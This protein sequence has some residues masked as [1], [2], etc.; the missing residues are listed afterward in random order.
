MVK[1][2]TL[3]SA[4]IS[5]LSPFVKTLFNIISERSD[6]VDDRCSNQLQN[7]AIVP[8]CPRDN[9]FSCFIFSWVGQNL[10]IS[11]HLNS[12]HSLIGC[13]VFTYCIHVKT[14]LSMQMA[15]IGTLS[16]SLIWCTLK[17]C[18][19]LN[20]Y[21]LGSSPWNHNNSTLFT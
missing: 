17:Y 8:N 20:N 6:N 12:I 16:S 4:W 11:S 9:N 10:A 13:H 15:T 2:N 19:A 3:I 7:L 21:L 5:S 14:N 1:L 18:S